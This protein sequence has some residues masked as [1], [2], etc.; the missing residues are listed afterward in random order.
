[1]TRPDPARQEEV[2]VV[3]KGSRKSGR[4]GARARARNNGDAPPPVRAGREGGAPGAGGRGGGEGRRRDGEE[5]GKVPAGARLPAHGPARPGR[6]ATWRD[7][8]IHTIR[9]P[10]L[11]G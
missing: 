2:G 6:G 7:R 5:G 11:F 10:A 4:G 8:P 1:M 3:S 9:V